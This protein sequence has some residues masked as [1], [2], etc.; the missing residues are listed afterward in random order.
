MSLPSDI[1]QNKA[2]SEVCYLVIFAARYFDFAAGY[3]DFDFAANCFV[4]WPASNS[5]SAMTNCRDD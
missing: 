4:R 2:G 3:F 5:A 1:S